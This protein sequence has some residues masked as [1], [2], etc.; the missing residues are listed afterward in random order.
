MLENYEISYYTDF[1]IIL[2]KKCNTSY[3]LEGVI[4]DNIIDIHN[5]YQMIEQFLLLNN[6]TEKLE[7]RCVFNNAKLNI[8]VDIYINNYVVNDGG[9]K[10]IKSSSELLDYLKERLDIESNNKVVNYEN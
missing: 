6:F 5:S 2:C 9:C 4:S 1:T 7:D 10:I 3:H 8:T